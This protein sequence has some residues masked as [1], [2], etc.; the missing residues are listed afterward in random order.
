[1]DVTDPSH[2]LGYP[3]LHL[4]HT[5]RRCH[6]HLRLSKLIGCHRMWFNQWAAQ[7]DWLTYVDV[8][9]MDRKTPGNRLSELHPPNDGVINIHIPSMR[10]IWL[11][12]GQ[13]QHAVRKSFECILKGISYQSCKGQGRLGRLPPLTAKWIDKSPSRI[14][15]PAQSNI[16]PSQRE[17]WKAAPT[18]VN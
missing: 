13:S 8:V 11:R 1:M 10:T 6:F 2:H 18:R 5:Q 15:V 9:A 14:L 12:K 16:V 17:P 3:N 4:D 7:R